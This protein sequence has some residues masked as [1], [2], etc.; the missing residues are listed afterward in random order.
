[1]LRGCRMWIDVGFGLWILGLGWV[2][3]GWTGLGVEIRLIVTVDIWDGLE[4]FEKRGSL[5]I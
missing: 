3:L 5:G 2:G 1:M 4:L